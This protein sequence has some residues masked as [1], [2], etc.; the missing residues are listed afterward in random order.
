[1]VDQQRQFFQKDWGFPELGRYGGLESTQFFAQI[2][3]QFTTTLCLS[4]KSERALPWGGSWSDLRRVG[5][6]GPVAAPYERER[7]HLCFPMPTSSMEAY[8]DGQPSISDVHTAYGRGQPA[9]GYRPP[10]YL[11]CTKIRVCLCKCTDK[12]SGRRVIGA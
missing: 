10:R 9:V 6:T 12:R 4:R 1:M 2:G 3:L 7:G 8:T 11:L 5:Q